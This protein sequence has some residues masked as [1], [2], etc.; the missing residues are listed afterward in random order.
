M[1][2][3]SEILNLVR[4]GQVVWYEYQAERAQHHANA[5]QCYVISILPILLQVIFSRMQLHVVV[6]SNNTTLLYLTTI[7]IL[8][9]IMT[10]NIIL[11][12]QITNNKR[13]RSR[14]SFQHFIYLKYINFHM[15][16]FTDEQKHIWK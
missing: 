7:L 15:N 13:K 10:S 4:T 6:Q 16:Q 5:S 8:T 3:C 12:F 11:C 14:Y 1:K 9:A 2:I